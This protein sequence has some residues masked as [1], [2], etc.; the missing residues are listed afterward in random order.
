MNRFRIRYT[1]TY[2]FEV[3]EPTVADAV[4]VAREFFAK[5]PKHKTLICVHPVSEPAP[6]VSHAQWVADKQRVLDKRR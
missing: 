2:E 1:V 6:D 3:V 4:M 5:T